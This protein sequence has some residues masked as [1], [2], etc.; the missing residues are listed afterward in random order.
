MLNWQ[1]SKSCKACPERRTEIGSTFFHFCQVKSGKCW[2]VPSRFGGSSQ[3]LK[4]RVLRQFWTICGCRSFVVGS[5]GLRRLFDRA[6]TWGQEGCLPKRRCRPRLAA[7]AFSPGR[8]GFCFLIR[9]SPRPGI[10]AK[11]TNENTTLK[12]K[13]KHTQNRSWGQLGFALR[14]LG[15]K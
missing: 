9:L 12:R 6:R 11:Q 10:C 15:R 3:I 14:K 8:V 7:K 13:D 2:N 5:F 4:I 1:C